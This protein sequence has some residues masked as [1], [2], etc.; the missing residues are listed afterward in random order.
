MSLILDLVCIIL[1]WILA[2]KGYKKG[3][4]KGLFGILS[5][6]LSGI[7]TAVVYQP[8]SE[9]IMSLSFVKDKADLVENKIA[10]SLIVSQQDALTGLP[11]WFS[12]IAL[13]MS[14][15]ANVAISST[16]TKII[17]SVFCI[18]AIYLIVKLAFRIF[19]GVFDL[20]MKLP[21]LNLLNRAG[22]AAC[23]VISAAMF[24]WVFL[25]CVVLFAGTTVFEPVNNA[26]QETSLV[27][28]FYNN[29]LLIKLIL[30]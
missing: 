15:N 26:I 17:V 12:D 25:A 24:L 18:V 21:V 29:N 10:D 22:G 14:N 20:I 28:Y 6:V 19:E 13:E 9:Y 11:K 5:F 3:L 30:K 23:G 27:K 2:A 7:V 16:V 1:I 4:V 8:V